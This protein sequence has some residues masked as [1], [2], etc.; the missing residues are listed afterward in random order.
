MVFIKVSL[1]EHLNVGRGEIEGYWKR[2]FFVTNS[3]L[4]KDDLQLI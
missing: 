4:I 1:T 3:F 2:Q